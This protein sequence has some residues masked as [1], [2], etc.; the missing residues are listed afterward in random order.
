MVGTQPGQHFVAEIVE[1]KLLLMFVGCLA[2]SDASLALRLYAMSRMAAGHPRPTPGRSSPAQSRRLLPSPGAAARPSPSPKSEDRRPSAPPRRPWP[3]DGTVGTGLCREND[4]MEP[5]G[6]GS[7]EAIDECRDR[8]AASGVK[9][10]ENQNDIP[11][12]VVQRPPIASPSSAGPRRSGTV[13]KAKRFSS[14]PGATRS[15]A[16]ATWAANRVRSASRAS[17]VTQ[18]ASTSRM[19]SHVM[20][21]LVFPCPAGAVTTVSHRDSTRSSRA[22]RCGRRTHAPEDRSLD[23]GATDGQRRSRR[24]QHAHATQLLARPGE[25]VTHPSGSRRCR[26]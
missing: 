24:R 13:S 11:L 3:G 1:Q 9:I 25:V 18:T 10:I 17:T 15:S 4:R 16:I 23:L 2:R 14:M 5:A 21:E 7:E 12:Q 26:A 20:I 22:S 19:R 6:R 8:A